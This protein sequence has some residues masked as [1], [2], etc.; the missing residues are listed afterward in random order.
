MRVAPQIP[1]DGGRAAEGGLRVDDP[2]C[3]KER[4]DEGVPLDRVP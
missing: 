2:V 3:L 4:I 1:K